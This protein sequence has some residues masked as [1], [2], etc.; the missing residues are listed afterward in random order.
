MTTSLPEKYPIGLQTFSEIIT[1]HYVYVDKTHY[2]PSLTQE[3]KY[4]FLSRPRRFGKSLLLSTLHSFFAG[5]RTLFKGLAVDNSDVEWQ[6]YPIIHIDLNAQN[7]HDEDGL[8]QILDNI[9]SIHAGIFKVSDDT[10]SSTPIRFANLIR[11]IYE[12]TGRQLVIL[13]DEYDKPLLEIEDNKALFIKNQAILKGFFSV[14]KTMDPYIRFAML[15][16]VARFNKVSIFSDLNNIKDISLSDRYADICGW[17]EDELKQYFPHGIQQM[18]HKLDL[19][20]EETILKMREFYDGYKFTPEGNRLYNPYS[21]LNA[22]ADSTLGSYWFQTGTPTFLVKRIKAAKILLPALNNAK[23]MRS[24]LESIGMDDTN[25]IPLL[26]QTGYL[27]IKHASGNRFELQ[28]PNKEV[29]TG[30]AEQLLPL[31]APQLK[32]FSSPFSLWEFQDD[33]SHGKPE[34]FMVRLQTL[35]KNVPYEQHNEKFYQNVT[36]LL[37][38]LCG[39]NATVEQ[40]SNL[41]RT[42]LEVLNSEYIYIFEFKYNGSAEEA[43]RQI[44]EK[45]YAGKFHLDPRQTFLIG[46]NFSSTARGLDHWIITTTN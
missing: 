33:L 24:D 1:K 27:T 19:S 16:G 5:E 34:E 35:I 36:Y 11:A 23:S 40:H 26:F 8:H 30:F 17:T 25:P 41:G 13:V 37:F 22:L 15:T 44:Q 10:S 2:I 43:I 12:Q 32:E 38:T 21:V 14:L 31:Y 6:S 18:A 29:E 20:V 3:N 9:L 46:A 45:D 28:F 42:D 4:I 39:A 7:Y